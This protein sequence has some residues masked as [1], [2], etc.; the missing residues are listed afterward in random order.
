MLL[1]AAVSAYMR[2]SP[3]RLRES[4]PLY[5]CNR[6]TVP[7]LVYKSALPCLPIFRTVNYGCVPGSNCCL[8]DTELLLRI[9]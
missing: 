9:R 6:L 7:F 5:D 2:I 3:Y 4:V 8:N 1:P